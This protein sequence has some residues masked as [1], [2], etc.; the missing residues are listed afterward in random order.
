MPETN[1][2]IGDNVIKRIVEPFSVD[3]GDRIFQ[4]NSDAITVLLSKAFMSSDGYMVFSPDELKSNGLARIRE[5]CGDGEI[6][7][8]LNEQLCFA[9]SHGFSV[10]GRCPFFITYE[11]FAP[12]VDS[13]VDQYVKA[14]DYYGNNNILIHPSLNII[15][16]SLGW[17]NVPTHHNP[18][19]V[20]RLILNNNNRIN[21]LFPIN[22]SNTIDSIIN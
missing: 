1:K 3:L 7:E 16:T 18:S 11:A 22:P 5:T 20:D 9:W 19:F 15:I 6:I 4:S 2:K 13:L 10:S 12:L 17:K 14:L 8:I 21:I